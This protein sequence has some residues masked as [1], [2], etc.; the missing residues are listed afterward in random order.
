MDR[1]VVP[2]D[3]A[4][5]PMRMAVQWTDA[6][7]TV[8]VG[9]GRGRV[10]VWSTCNTVQAEAHGAAAAAVAACANDAHNSSGI[11]WQME[12]PLATGGGT[13]LGTRSL[14]TVGVTDLLV[15]DDEGGLAWWDTFDGF[16]VGVPQN[17]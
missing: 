13:S 12:L 7:T 3:I 6:A 2:A 14:A 9:G 16:Q 11:K 17:L 4:A 8:F 10:G 15:I 5:E 1:V